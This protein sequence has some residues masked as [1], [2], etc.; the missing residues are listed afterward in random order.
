MTD[1]DEALQATAYLREFINAYAME[2]LEG[3]RAWAVDQGYEDDGDEDDGDPT[4]WCLDRFI[5]DLLEVQ[6]YAP[7]NDDGYSDTHV[8]LVVTL[9]GP[10]IA[11]ERSFF[12]D[13]IYVMANHGHAQRINPYGLTQFVDDVLE[14][15]GVIL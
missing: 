4:S 3:L 6:V 1:Y 5:E 8:L 7:T 13:S 9:G 2:D 11:I 12:G 15:M 10:Y 14:A